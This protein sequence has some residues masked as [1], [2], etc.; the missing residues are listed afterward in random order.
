MI[1]LSLSGCA[2]MMYSS[3]PEIAQRDRYSPQAEPEISL[4]TITHKP[5]SF[6]WHSALLITADERILYESGGYWK[7]PEDRRLADVHYNL[8]DERLRDYIARRGD[9]DVWQITLHRVEVS[10]D[11]ALEAKRRAQTNQLVLGGFCAMGVAEV[12]KGLPGFDHLGPVFLPHDLVPVFEEIPDVE[13]EVL[14]GA[15]TD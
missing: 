7:D 2:G 4:L 6:M 5:T 15:E 12:L 3:P 1:A 11:I 8:T 9:P 14:S 10:E 13:L